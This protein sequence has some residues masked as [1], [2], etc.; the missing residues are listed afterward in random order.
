MNKCKICKKVLGHNNKSKLC[1][2]CG[3]MTVREYFKKKLGEPKS[4]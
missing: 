2:N 3:G 1:S 4:E